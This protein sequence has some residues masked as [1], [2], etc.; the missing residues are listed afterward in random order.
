MTL[1]SGYAMRRPGPADLV[2][3]QALLDDCE[4]AD[5]GEPRAHQLDVVAE[6]RRPSVDIRRDWS[7]IET[8]ERGSGRLRVAARLR[9]GEFHRRAQRAPRPR[10]QRSGRVAPD[11]PRGEG[12]R[13]RARARRRGAWSAERLVRRRPGRPSRPAAR[14]RLRQVARLL[15]HAESIFVRGARGPEPPAGFRCARPAGTDERTLYE[16]TRRLRRA[17]QLRARYPRGLPGRVAARDVDPELWLVGWRRRGRGEV[18]AVVRGANVYVES[19]SVRKPVARPRPG[20]R[21]APAGSAGCTTGAGTT[22][23]SASTPRRGPAPAASTRRPACGS[24]GGSSCSSGACHEQAGRGGAG[25]AA[26]P[27]PERS[28][29]CAR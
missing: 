21:P 12:G 3:A 14:S 19:V 29:S 18:A 22:S 4:A 17:L 11:G 23:S 1:P 28:F 25:R 7:V 16:A 13:D 20:A 9:L 2:A 5:T 15:P 27:R 8:A 24:G 6:S 26:R 10:G